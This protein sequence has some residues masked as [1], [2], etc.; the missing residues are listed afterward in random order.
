MDT[1]VNSLQPSKA[2][3]PIDV[4]VFGKDIAVILELAKALLIKDVTFVK[5]ANSLNENLS[6]I[7]ANLFPKSSAVTF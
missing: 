5:Y 1:S 3:S 2:Y 4:N 6:E 7:F